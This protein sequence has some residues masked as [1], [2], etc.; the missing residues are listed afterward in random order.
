GLTGLCRSASATPPRHKEPVPVVSKSPVLK[1][2]KQVVDC[3]PLP[4]PRGRQRTAPGPWGPRSLDDAQSRPAGDVT[5]SGAPPAGTLAASPDG[6]ELLDSW[7]TP[8]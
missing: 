3:F 4:H 8:A 1:N 6:H 2:P 7:S 5:V